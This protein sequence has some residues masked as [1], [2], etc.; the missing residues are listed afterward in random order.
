MDAP[1]LKRKDE[2]G[3]TW[4]H[5]SPD[6]KRHISLLKDDNPAPDSAAQRVSKARAEKIHTTRKPTGR[7][8]LLNDAV[9]RADP[10][11]GI[12]V[13]AYTVQQDVPGTSCTAWYERVC[14]TMG[15]APTPAPGTSMRQYAKEHATSLSTATECAHIE[16]E[17]SVLL[18]QTT[19]VT[20]AIDLL[21]ARTKL[22]QLAEDRLSVLPPVGAHAPQ[23][24][25]NP[26]CGFDARI[27]W[28]DEPFSAWSASEHARAMLQERVPLDGT[29]VLPVDEPPSE[30]LPTTGPAV[31]CGEAKRRCKR[32]TD[33]SITRGADLEM[34]RDMQT[35]YLSA[36][37]EREQE[38]RIALQSFT[39]HRIAT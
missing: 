21:A 15:P 27:C 13:W 17:L 29:L 22:V 19:A 34:A 25:K 2:R 24:G 20:A 30:A 39:A 6:A 33:W 7:A 18:Q 5:L 37:A 31:V 32:H 26:R 4:P 3:D 8:H 12:T 38:L 36:L 23:D 16:H 10:R 35:H 28:D 1:A 14:S 9:R 11:Q